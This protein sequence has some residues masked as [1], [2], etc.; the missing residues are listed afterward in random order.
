MKL[1]TTQ[2]FLYL[3][4]I[5]G[6]LLL[7]TGFWQHVPESVSSQIPEKVRIAITAESIVFP[8]LGIL[9]IGF[10]FA[11]LKIIREV[12]EE[13]RGLRE[14]IGYLAETVESSY[15]DSE[16]EDQ[17]DESAV[18]YCSFCDKQQGDVWKIITGPGVNICSE[19]VEACAEL[20]KQKKEAR[21]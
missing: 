20:L 14:E 12:R 10:G 5:A 15:D 11:L 6:M 1:R 8:I 9:L 18:E 3:I 21:E 13:A 19:C 16:Y 2:I 4:I 7:G 17:G